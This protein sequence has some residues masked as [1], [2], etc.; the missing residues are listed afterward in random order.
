[1]AQDTQMNQKLS[2]KVALVTGASKSIGQGLAVGLAGAGARVAVNYKNDLAG[3]EATCARIGQAGGEA[4]AFQADI[5]AK[6]EFE[7]LV[8]RVCERFG[9]LDVLVNNAARTRFGHVFDITEEDFDDVV[10][11]NLR[12]PFFGS[13]AAARRMIAQGGGGAI[14]NISSC[15]AKVIIPHHSSYTMAKGGLESLTRQLAI[16]LAPHVRVNAIAPAPTSNARNLAY[17]QDYDRKWAA[18]M[19]A[20][21]V[22]QVE[23]Y[24]GPCVFLASDDAALL[25]GQILNVDG[26]WTLIGFTPDLSRFDFSEDR[27]RG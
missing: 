24:V 22:A 9:R 18:V 4:E 7:Q 2:G 25:T 6:A 10:N 27:K 26:G 1:M 16:E 14:I 8:D 20:K 12:G 19:P 5:G 21:R 13:A 15:A 3:A 23:D 17:D 11:T